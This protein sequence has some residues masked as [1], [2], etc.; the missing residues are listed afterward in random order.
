M[1]RPAT[2]PGVAAAGRS[3]PFSRYATLLALLVAGLANAPALVA[4]F[5]F[6]ERLQ[7]SALETPPGDRFGALAPFHLWRFHLG[8]EL[9]VNQNVEHGWLEW[10]RAPERLG[11]HMAFL[12]PLPSA[13]LQLEHGA[14]GSNAVGYHAASLGLFL[15]VV[16]LCVRLYHR[17]LP[18]RLAALAA[19]AFAT[20]AHHWESAGVVCCL[21]VLLATACGSLALTH[22]VAWRE[23]GG[24]LPAL[25]SCL[26]LAA[27]ALCGES[28]VQTFVYF[29]AYEALA[30]RDRPLARAAALAP[31]ASISTALVVAHV[32]FGFGANDSGY[33]PLSRDGL[34]SI[35]RALPERAVA[36]WGEMLLGVPNLI[37]LP[38][39]VTI[40]LGIAAVWVLFARALRALPPEPARHARWLGAAALAS[41]PPSTLGVVGSRYLTIPSVGGAVLLAVVVDGLWRWRV[42]ERHHRRRAATMAF[43]ALAAAHF[44]AGPCIAV[45]SLGILRR[46]NRDLSSGPESWASRLVT[47]GTAGRGHVVALRVP[48]GFSAPIFRSTIGARVRVWPVA[49]VAAPLIL[50]RPSPRSLEL[51]TLPGHPGFYGPGLAE[52]PASCATAAGLPRVVG[53]F[54]VRAISCENGALTRIR[55]EFDT[56]LDDPRVRFVCWQASAQS[57]DECRPPPEGE[58]RLVL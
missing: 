10:Y 53:P 2:P 49:E 46:H 31:A 17:L 3:M 57:L 36:L 13:V 29:V 41:V 52:G 9:E 40:S 47:P 1:S 50:T 15:A 39:P 25:A 37:G 35:L 23:R 38:W 34:A 20:A 26:W 51:S 55:L 43:A 21:H 44:A 24:R 16:A 30:R 12:R 7:L 11:K 5:H 19:L 32:A 6:E 48:P 8:T 27:A 18:P 56:S 33:T 45:I 42:D 14:F 58:Q 4:G 28:I 22:H 54:L